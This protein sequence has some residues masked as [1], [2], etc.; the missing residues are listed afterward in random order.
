MTDYTSQQ[1]G[2]QPGWV[3]QASAWIEHTLAGQ[4]IRMTGPI[5]QVHRVPWSTVL[6][7]PTTEG[8][9]YF[10]APMPALVHEVALT[11][12]LSQWRPDCVL[13]LLA[14]ELERG[15]MLLPDGGTRLREVIRAEGD[16]RPWEIVLP[17]YA[18]LQMDMVSHREEIL[19]LGVPDRRLAVLP[20]LLEELLTDEQVLGINHPD[21]LTR[22]EVER[23]RERVP[24]VT[25]TCQELA[26]Y[27]IPESLDHQDLNDG[28]I[29]AGD[30]RSIFFDWSEASITHPFFSLRTVVVSVELTLDL[31]EG[32]APVGPLRDAYLEPWTRRVARED[33]VRAFQ[34]AQRLWMLPGA[35][36]WHRILSSLEGTEREEYAYTVPWL[37]KE[38]LG[39]NA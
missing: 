10:K 39:A 30:S 9:V 31:E 37:L 3:D 5:G 18:A 19:A 20:H 2:R 4:G 32:S 7:V 21:Y 23:L 26:R 11:Q 36:A 13:P 29:F 17:T 22:D 35:L 8:D 24:A 27:A 28:N 38:F 15:W 1:P 33:L 6:R 14:V 12:A 25:A 16:S 34:L